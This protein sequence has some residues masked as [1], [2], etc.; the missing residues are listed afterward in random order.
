MNKSGAV[1]S[2]LYPPK[3]GKISAN[4]LTT[5]SPMKI[6]LTGANG[7]IGQ[8]LLQVLTE[9][10]HEVYAVVRD[11]N[12]FQA[13]T[14]HPQLVKVTEINFLE[15]PDVSSLP[16][17]FDVAF[18][19][20]HSMSSSTKNFAVLEA[21]TATNFIKYVDQTQCRQ[22][23]FL[24]GLMPETK[25]SMHLQSRKNVEEILQSAQTPATILRAGIIIGSGSASFEIIRD[26]V[27]KIPVM[28]TPKWVQTRCQPIAVR[29]I[30]SY[31]KGVMLQPKAYNQKFDVGGR[32]VLT[33]KEMMLQFAAIR[34]LKRRIFTVPVMTPRLSSYW[35]YFITSTSYKLAVNL[36]D[37]MKVEAVMHEDRIREIVPLTP[38]SYRE[39]IRLA[40]ERIE[41][42]MVVSSWKDALI[43]SSAYNKLNTYIEVPRYGCFIDQKQVVVNHRAERVLENIW[44]VGGHNGWYY[45]TWLWGLRGL[46]D[47]M[48]GG[49]GLRRGRTNQNT[50]K[51]GD[52]LDF[53]RVLV[54]DRQ[55]RRLLLYAEMKLPGEAWL[56]FHIQKK[57]GGDML[58]QTATFRPQGLKGRLY[59]HMLKPFH[60]FIFRGMARRIANR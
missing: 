15:T 44:S 36:V 43:T 60:L 4:Q 11:K 23:V 56:E 18:F 41:Q 7:Y 22:I 39:S 34:G 9:D 10:G 27:E 55:N 6:L 45:A 16:K 5:I 42:N 57:D 17:D 53:W 59:W 1:V 26:L 47:K 19:L 14:R 49:T 21:E 28:I 3:R 30:V 58:H 25:L 40:F 33:Y 46:L 29:D 8:R 32:E 48:V 13:N 38:V 35:L 31:L 24:S 54:A 2:V 51:P 50:I 52:A 37:S 20:I 12:R